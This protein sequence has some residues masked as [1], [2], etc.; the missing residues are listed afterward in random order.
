MLFSLKKR[1]VFPIDVWVRR[2]MNELYIK[3]IDENRV[4]KE[5]IL[6][7]AKE[8]YGN[9]AGIAQQ[10]LFYWKRETS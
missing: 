7:L 3:S 2:V 4:K 9:L 10:Y 6:K 8:K 1:E 5:E